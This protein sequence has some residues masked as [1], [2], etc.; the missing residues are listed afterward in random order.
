MYFGILYLTFNDISPSTYTSSSLP[1]RSVCICCLSI[2]SIAL[3]SS[4]SLT[5]C[6]YFLTFLSFSIYFTMLFSVSP[7]NS[8]LL[9]TFCMIFLIVSSSDHYYF[10]HLLKYAFYSHIS[11]KYMCFILINNKNHAQYSTLFKNYFTICI[12]VAFLG[13]IISPVRLFFMIPV[14]LSSVYVGIPILSHHVSAIPL[15]VCARKIALAA[16]VNSM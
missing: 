10:H 6:L 13:F 15:P 14:S 2:A 7:F 12:W 9:I 11:V 5:V 8:M 1:Y 3:I 16:V 4:L